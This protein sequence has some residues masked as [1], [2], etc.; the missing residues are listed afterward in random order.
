MK[1]L[2]LVGI[3]LSACARG[4]AIVVLQTSPGLQA[5]DRVDLSNGL[6]VYVAKTQRA[7]LFSEVLLV[8][9]AGTD[10][11]NPQQAEIAK[12]TADAFLS[13]RRSA[14]AP[15]VRVEFAR[16]GVLPDYTIGRDVAVFRFAIPSVNTATFLHILS[17]LLDRSSLA[18]SVWSDAIARRGQE[19]AAERSDLWQQAT[20]EL[21]GLVWKQEDEDSR[22]KLSLSSSAITRPALATFW[23]RSYVLGNMVLSVWG[24]T[25]VGDLKETIQREFGRLKSQSPIMPNPPITPALSKDRSV[26]CLEHEGAAPAALLVGL[27]IRIRDDRDFYAW[28]MAVHILGAS[29]NSRLQRRLRT[30]SQVVYTV[31]AAALPIG[32]NGMLLRVACQTD[33]VETTQR[34]ILQ[35]L[36]QL[37]EQPVTQKEVDLARAILRSRLKLDSVSFRDQFYRRSL[38]LLLPRTVRDPQAAAP[39]LSSFTPKT[40]LNVLKSTVHAEEASSVV[41]STHAEPVCGSSSHESNP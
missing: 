24:D 37:V 23:Q 2:L 16:L 9:R 4:D 14:D 33:Q 7:A 34:I 18:E 26:I 3:L 29:Y 12:I 22:Q 13:E 6:R 8:V 19:L 15:P 39:I 1:T 21:T 20:S 11:Y 40:L 38:A 25:P 41:V 31:E 30:E 36:R 35:E 32:T 5:L 27:G 10:T 28:Q 17:D